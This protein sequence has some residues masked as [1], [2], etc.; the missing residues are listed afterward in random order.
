M[1]LHTNKEL[2]EQ[3]ILQ[4][5][6]KSGIEPGI[7][8]KDYYVSLLLK[9]LANRLPA[10]IFKG[11]TSLSKCHKVI[12]RFSEDIDITLDEQHLTQGNR[13]SV[14]VAIEDACDTLGFNIA[15]INDIKSRM[16]FN[17]YIIE[18]P[19]LFAIAGIKPDIEIDTIFSIRSFPYETKT[20]TSII[21][22][23][24]HEMG[25]YEFI[26][27]YELLPFAV[28]TQSIDR[29]FIDKIFALCDYYLQGKTR[30]RSRHLYDIYKLYPLISDLDTMR[31]L[32]KQTR[33]ARIDSP[34]CESAN[35]S[36]DI[37]TLLKEIADKDF[38]RIDYKENTSVLLYE[39]VPYETA[40]SAI[41]KI[42]E[43][44]IF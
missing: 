11:G 14:K 7:I 9:E 1:K 19:G 17:H 4:V 13:K 42:I 10:M 35:I 15:N 26:N 12:K 8:E 28:N 2:F 39:D 31:K 5:A 29:T 43:D 20:A 38:Y 44:R 33:E 25:L 37:N 3:T 32:A 27:D 41:Y 30:E 18:Y 21:Y 23:Y 16:D 24:L 6:Q 40:K 22:D 34:F 36:I